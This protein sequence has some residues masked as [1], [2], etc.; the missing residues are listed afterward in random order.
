M[1]LELGDIAIDVALKNIK[2][3]HL[4]VHPPTGKVTISAPL[5]MD[6]NAI[7]VFAISK[8]GWIRL[9]QTKVREQERETEREYLDRESHYVW[10]NRCLLKAIEVEAVPKIE[11]QHN[12]LLMQVRPGA[13]EVAKEA[14][15][16]N[17]YRRQLKIE[18]APLIQTWESRLSVKAD[19]FYIQ[20]MKTKWAVA[21]R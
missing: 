13:D 21:T 14:L 12:T 3:V 20:R 4:S 1:Q 5:R 8:L 11:L 18:A 16:A 19:G 9:Q 10:G 6:M 2:N 7:R 17:W 15:V